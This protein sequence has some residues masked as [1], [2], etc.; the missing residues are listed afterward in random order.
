MSDDKKKHQITRVYD[1]VK[2]GTVNPTY[3]NPL[4]WLWLI[5]QSLE[6]C[7]CI[8]RLMAEKRMGRGE[9]VTFKCLLNCPRKDGQFEEVR[10]TSEE[11]MKTL[12][13]TLFVNNSWLFIPVKT[14]EIKEENG[15]FFERRLFILADFA[16]LLIMDTVFVKTPHPN[17]QGVASKHLKI[18]EEVVNCRIWANRD[19]LGLSKEGFP[20]IILPYLEN[21]EMKLGENFFNYVLDDAVTELRE[22]RNDLKRIEK[23]MKPF[24]SIRE[25]LGYVNCL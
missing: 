16:E 22:K 14:L 2:H 13:K 25:R 7:R 5:E 6:S 8:L 9:V 10:V 4:E 23:E 18:N 17:Q 15:Q 19:G 20:E 11:V 21:S 1:F 12:P 3:L 24:L